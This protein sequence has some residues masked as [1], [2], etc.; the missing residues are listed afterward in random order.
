[1]TRANKLDTTSPTSRCAWTCRA[2][3]F[4]ETCKRLCPLE[5]RDGASMSEHC[6]QRRTRQLSRLPL[7]ATS[8][9]AS[10]AND[11]PTPPHSAQRNFGQ[12]SVLQE[13]SV[14][15]RFLHSVH[16]HG[17]SARAGTSEGIRQKLNNQKCHGWI[18]RRGSARGWMIKPF[19]AQGCGAAQGQAGL[20]KGAPFR[21][22][23]SRCI[24]PIC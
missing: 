17:I 10:T 14:W 11:P 9:V 20:R 22:T 12:P 23:L 18:R 19:L 21:G 15:V 16:V 2:R 6:H 4:S 5:C 3:R 8:P 24:E 7:Q 13:P 1:M